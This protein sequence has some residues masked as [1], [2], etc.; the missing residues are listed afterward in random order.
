MS[1][2]EAIFDSI[3]GWQASR[4]TGACVLVAGSGALGNEVLKNLALLGVGQV[5]L[6]D[7][8]H[9]EAHNLSRSILFREE[10][11]LA[12]RRK[13]DAAAQRLME[14]NPNLS[15][16]TLHGDLMHSLG[17]GLLKQMDIAIG[18]LDNRLARLYLNRLCWR[19]GIPW[20]DGGILQLSGQVTSYVPGNSCYE[21]QLSLGEWQEIRV[22]MGCA[23]MG[24]RYAQS[25]RM[26]TTPLA[27][28]II[29]AIQVQ[30]ALKLIHLPADL[31]SGGQMFSY[32]GQQLHAE[33]Y[34]RRPLSENCLSH[35]I[36]DNVL[37][38]NGFKDEMPLGELLSFAQDSLGLVRPYISLPHGL[39]LEVAGMADAVPRNV[40]MPKA[41]FT[42]GL[43][44][45]LGKGRGAVGIPKG[46]MVEKIGLDFARPD[47]PLWRFGIAFGDIVEL[48]AENGQASVALGG[49]LLTVKMGAGLMQIPSRWSGVGDVDLAVMVEN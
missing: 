14:I 24:R 22:R 46:G 13:V 20:V 29:G 47:L 32:E 17:L 39:V 36:L 44:T 27:A 28:S 43:A 25:A 35:H 45:E 21:C 42:D 8:D 12:G 31:R 18:C 10:D 4:I 1:R 3:Q 2:G 6:V 30:E 37:T 19:A 26:P 41:V 15:V 48:K 49:D 9:V 16:L 23:D 38:D 11:A 33:S 5:L 40:V 7:F 34:Q